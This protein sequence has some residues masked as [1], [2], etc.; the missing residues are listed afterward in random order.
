MA[1]LYLSLSLSVYPYLSHTLCCIIKRFALFLN[2]L[3]ARYAI[4][5]CLIH[6]SSNFQQAQQSMLQNNTITTYNARE[7]GREIVQLLVNYNKQ[8]SSIDS[9]A[10]T[11]ADLLSRYSKIAGIIHSSPLPPRQAIS[12]EHRKVCYKKRLRHRAGCLSRQREG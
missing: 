8:R 6:S 2:D 11:L 12:S 7:E 5:A 9:P 10:H 1:T 3:F 4:I